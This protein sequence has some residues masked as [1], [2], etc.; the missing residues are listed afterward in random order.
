MDV[1]LLF[2]AKLVPKS[3]F[4][5]GVFR[6][7]EEFPEGMEIAVAGSLYGRLYNNI[8]NGD[9]IDLCH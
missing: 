7:I 1:S 9:G 3:A 6:G 2:S 8:G 4:L 5:V